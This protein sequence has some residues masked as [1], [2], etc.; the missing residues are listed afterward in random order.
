[1]ITDFSFVTKMKIVD[2][3]HLLLKVRKNCID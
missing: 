3:N 2:Q 1:V